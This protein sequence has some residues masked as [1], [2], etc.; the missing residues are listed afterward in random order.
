MELL[1]NLS[2]WVDELKYV[3]D[4]VVDARENIDAVSLSVELGGG[5]QGQKVWWWRSEGGSFSHL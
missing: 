3:V 1:L 4:D 5:M 2:S